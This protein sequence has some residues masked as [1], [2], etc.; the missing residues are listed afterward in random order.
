MSSDS[1]MITAIATCIGV[2]V[3][4][5][6]LGFTGFQLRQLKNQI[7]LSNLTNVLAL[8][9][10]INYRKEKVDDISHKIVVNPNDTTL[11]EPLESAVENWIN[12]VDRLCFCIRKGYFPEKEWSI[13]YRDYIINLVRSN[14]GKFGPGSRYVHIIYLNNKW[15][16][17]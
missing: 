17:K 3:G 10:E 5:L 1:E 16:E 2:G 4:F 13:E 7:R 15:K 14:E 8:E 12:S 9:T 11:S 6:G